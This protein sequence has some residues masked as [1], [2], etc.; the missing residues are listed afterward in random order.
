MEVS[1]AA[2]VGWLVGGD[3]PEFPLVATQVIARAVAVYIAGVAIV[4]LGESRLISGA[5]PLDVILGFI[6]GLLL[7]PLA[8][9][10]NFALFG[11]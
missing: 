1:I 5:T 11:M 4:R 3:T 7:K 9:C 8:V 10:T 6:L 2:N